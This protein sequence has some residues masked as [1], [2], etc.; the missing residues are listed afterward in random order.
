VSVGA[1][2]DELD[3]LAS[4]RFPAEAG[5]LRLFLDELARSLAEPGAAAEAVLLLSRLE[6]FLEALLVRERWR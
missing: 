1:C 4:A 5:T 6:E 3:A 2:L